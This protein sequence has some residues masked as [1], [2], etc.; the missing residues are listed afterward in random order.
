MDCFTIA[1]ASSS[2]TNATEWFC[3]E[4]VKLVSFPTWLWPFGELLKTKTNSPKV[5]LSSTKTGK[6]VLSKGLISWET[7]FTL[8]QSEILGRGHSMKFREKLLTIWVQIVNAS[9]N[10]GE[11]RLNWYWIVACFQAAAKEVGQ[12]RLCPER[13]YKLSRHSVNM[14]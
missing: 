12:I 10:S 6:L 13:K 1:K 3:C 9:K 4:R 5:T 2:K 14:V 8:F 11:N 7:N